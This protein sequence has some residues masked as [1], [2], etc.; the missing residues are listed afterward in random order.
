MRGTTILNGD[1]DHRRLR[2]TVLAN[3]G[4]TRKHI[5]EKGLG[6]DQDVIASVC[7]NGVIVGRY[8]SAGERPADSM[9]HLFQNIINLSPHDNVSHA[10]TI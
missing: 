2:S 6:P 8:Q 4:L 7:T 9:Q 3:V 1:D 5:L 10:N